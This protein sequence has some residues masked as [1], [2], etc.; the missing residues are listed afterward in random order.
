MHN[1]AKI[2]IIKTAPKNQLKFKLNKS[3]Q[4]KKFQLNDFLDQYLEDDKKAS[5]TIGSGSVIDPET[6]KL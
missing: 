2:P 4:I 3:K 5:N 1:N 6:L